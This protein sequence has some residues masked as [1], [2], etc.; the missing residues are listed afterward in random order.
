MKLQ[1]NG[2]VREFKRMVRALK[3]LENEL[4]TAGVLTELPSYFTE[5][6][7]YNVPN[8][9]LNRAT[10]VADMRAVLMTIFNETLTDEKCAKWL[11]ASELKWLFHSAQSWTRQQAHALADK[12]WDHMGFE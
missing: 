8:D 1:I 5:C 10:Y 3:R 11:E 7:V 2:A 4:V 12:A 6:L 9:L